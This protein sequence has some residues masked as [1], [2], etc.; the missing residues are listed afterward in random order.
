[1]QKAQQRL[2]FLRLLKRHIHRH[3]P[4]HVSCLFLL[5]SGTETHL[6]AGH[7][8]E[9][10]QNYHYSVKDHRLQTPHTGLIIPT[11]HHL[12]SNQDHG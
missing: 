11:T 12:M 8:E 1:M 2:Y 9:N 7:N 5:L 10:G 3:N 4:E 6:L